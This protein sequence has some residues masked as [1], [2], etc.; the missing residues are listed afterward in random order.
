[1]HNLE[2]E[3]K[4][5]VF[6]PYIPTEPRIANSNARTLPQYYLLAAQLGYAHKL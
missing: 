3:Q 6:I 2:R 5:G 1:M 4:A